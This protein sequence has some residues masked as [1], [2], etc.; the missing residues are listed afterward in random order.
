MNFFYQI[1]KW[2]FYLVNSKFKNSFFDSLMPFLTDIKSWKAPIIFSLSLYFLWMFLTPI[3]DG[4]SYEDGSENLSKA[5]KKGTVFVLMV[6]VGLGIG[7][8]LSHQVIKP[9]FDRIRP[10]NVLSEVNLLAPCNHS[11][12]FPSSHAVNVA[13]L[14]VIMSFA[15]PAFAP[16]IGTIAILVVYSRVYVGVHYPFDVLGGALFGIACGKAA[17]FLKIKFT[18]WLLWR[19]RK[20]QISGFA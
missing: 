2:C 18:N 17:I 8:S 14:A 19:M 10:C 5:M 4:G 1:D 20:N 12:S 3:M 7:D 6:L 9:F 16:V 15:Y 13:T 11:Y